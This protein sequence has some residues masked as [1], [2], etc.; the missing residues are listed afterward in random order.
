MHPFGL[1][2]AKGPMKLWQI[3]WGNNYLFA[4]NWNLKYQT[5]DNNQTWSLIRNVC[6]LR[7]VVTWYRFVTQRKNNHY[8][9]MDI[10]ITQNGKPSSIEHGY[11]GDRLHMMTSSN[12][13]IFRVTGHLCGE[14]TGSPVNFP[15]QLPVTRSFDVFLDL[16]LNK[17]LS[18][19]SWGWWFGT[20]SR[21]SWPHCSAITPV[22]DSFS[23]PGTYSTQNTLHREQV[24]KTTDI[25]TQRIL[26][27]YRWLVVRYPSGQNMHPIRTTRAYGIV[28]WT[29]T[30]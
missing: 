29:Y 30:E 5:A 10:C 19:Q 12:G 13:S 6:V 4:F 16:H 25:D 8:E 21:P 15:S 1:P 22:W 7:I 9:Y 14:F 20:Q 28:E 18:K 3:Y 24:S 26:Y 27:T 2:P 17:R 11:T 23:S